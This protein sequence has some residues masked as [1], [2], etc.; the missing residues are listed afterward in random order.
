MKKISILAI[1]ILLMSTVTT[2]F[3]HPGKNDHQQETQSTNFKA[4]L[5]PL[6]RSGVHGKAE[7][8][9][10]GDQLTVEMN[11][12]GFESNQTHA[13]HIH[14]IAGQAATCPTPA[15]DANGDHIVDFS[16]GLP[17]YG[18]VILPLTPFSTTPDGTEHYKA[19]FTIDPTTIGNLATRVIVLHGLTVDGSYVGS[20]PVACGKIRAHN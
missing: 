14:G 3:A 9:L 6:N 5:V 13:Q 1:L 4:T 10:E 2:V 18:P 17:Y 16:E 20:L 15:A 19:T 11:V 7:L 12:R 8:T